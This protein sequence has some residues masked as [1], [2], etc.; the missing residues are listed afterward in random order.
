MATTP[1]AHAAP[2]FDSELEPIL[3]QLKDTL[4]SS[5]T[6]EMIPLIRQAPE[7][8]VAELIGDRALTHRE[9]VVPGPDGAPDITLSAF[10]RDDH[11]AGGP[12]I[13]HIHG[14]GMIIGS[15]FSGVSAMFDW[16]ESLDAVCVSVEYRL[17]PEHPDPAPVDD[18]YAGLCWASEHADELGFDAGRMLV[19]GASAGG[20]LAAG[21][22]LRARDEGGP[23]LA[24]S[25]LIYP[26]L[27]DRNETVSSQQIAGIG[28]WDRA[29]NDTGWDALLGDRRR[30]DAVSIYAA[31]ARAT[32]LSGLP[33]TFIDVGTAEVFRD[34]DVA[35]ASQIWADGGD[36]ELH[37]WP[38]GFHGFDLMAPESD[39][40]RRM[41][42]VRSAWVTRVLTR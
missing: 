22:T 33:P 26:M 23:R 28:V 9:V 40:A 17:A 29:S 39:L 3:Q 2:P 15:R 34:E 5:I 16:V 8:T 11:R 4:P 24:G 1:A 14:G 27:D 32:D 18:C 19:A 7:P 36:C 6:P 31:P 38:G 30:T 37:V 41:V 35:Y 25:L 20:G 42:A 12:G 13:F 10:A 21:V